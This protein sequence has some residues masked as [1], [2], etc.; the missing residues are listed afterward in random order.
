MSNSNTRFT[1]LHVHTEYSLL[2]GLSRI[3]DLVVRAANDGMDALAITDHGALYGAVEFYSQCISAG[4]KPII[5]CEV[6]AAHGS[7]H[8]KTPSEKRPYHLTVLAKDNVGYRNLMQLVSKAHLEGFYYKPGFVDQFKLINLSKMAESWGYESAWFNERFDIPEK[9][10]LPWTIYPNFFE[11]IITISY[12]AA[13][14]QNIIHQLPPQSKLWIFYPFQKAQTKAN[15]NLIR[16]INLNDQTI[17]N[18]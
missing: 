14:T 12:I 9:Q 10:L 13:V 8:D 5:G 3:K 18:K 16:F 15:I 1:H 17:S 6:Y 7:R 2:D 4:I 11:V